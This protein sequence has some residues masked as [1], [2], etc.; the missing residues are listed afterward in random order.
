MQYNNNFNGY[1]KDNLEKF[2][3]NVVFTLYLLY[4]LNYRLTGKVLKK[5]TF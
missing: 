5:K 3:T 1:N 2:K 4:V